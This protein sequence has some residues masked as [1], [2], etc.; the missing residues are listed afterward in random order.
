MAISRRKF[1]GSSGIG[2]LGFYVSGCRVELTPEQAK[3]EHADFTILSP[4]EVT[5]L[6]A[7]GDVLVPG[8]SNKGIAHF[9]DHQLHAAPQEQLL[10]V[11]FL[12]VNPPFAGFYKG[13]LKALDTVAMTAHN[14]IFANLAAEQ[15]VNL[16]AELAQKNPAG[17]SGP[18]APFF[19]FVLR[20]DAVDVS[21]GTQSGFESLGIPYM[22][23][24]PPAS[25][26]GE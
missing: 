15:K 17:W 11:K 2:L 5:A 12:G 13:G 14:K 6:E 19:Y 18:P 3:S 9:I 7:L 10:M 4:V 23:H 8:S 26:W 22:A 21:Y 24:I 25:E 20:N 16:V 1:L